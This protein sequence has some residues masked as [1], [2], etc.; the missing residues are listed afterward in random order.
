MQTSRR[1]RKKVLQAFV[2][3]RIRFSL[4]LIITCFLL[5]IPLYFNQLFIFAIETVIILY[6]L[7]IINAYHI[8]N[9]VPGLN[10]S[11]RSIRCLAA[12]IYILLSMVS[13]SEFL[14]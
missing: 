4:G 6:G 11:N 10:C 1:E 14:E 12:V 2:R 13:L 3:K 5:G 9:F 8:R 7:L